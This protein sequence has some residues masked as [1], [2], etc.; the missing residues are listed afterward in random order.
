M[1]RV[2][3]FKTL[4]RSEC[5]HLSLQVNVLNKGDT[6][7]WHY[8]TNDGV[9]S[10]VVQE[11]DEGGAFEY[12]PYIRDED[13]ENYS[14]VRRLFEEID[15]PKRPAM[16]PGTLSLFLGR[17]S[18]HRVAPVGTT[19]KPRLSL[20]LSYDAKPGMVFPPKTVASIL[21]P[22]PEPYLGKRA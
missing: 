4:Y 13:D 15:E 21:N 12:A 2:L 3:D 1:R 8:D 9:V 7:G 14:G 20:L 19:Q 10:F 18:V 5:P 11:A 6:F 16:P 22:S 17:R